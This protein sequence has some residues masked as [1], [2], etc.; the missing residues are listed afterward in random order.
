MILYMTSST[1]KRIPPLSVLGCDTNV[2]NGV[3]CARYWSLILKDAYEKEGILIPSTDEKV[4][5]SLLQ[6]PKLVT[7]DPVIFPSVARIPEAML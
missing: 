1:P 5:F 3:S 6:T 4:E 7:D 2:T